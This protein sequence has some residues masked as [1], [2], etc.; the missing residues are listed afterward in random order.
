MNRPAG[1]RTPLNKF[2]WGIIPLRTIFCRVSYLA[3]QISSG[4]QTAVNKFL[5]GL[6]NTF[7]RVSYLKEQISEEYRGFIYWRKKNLPLGR[8]Y[9]SMSFGGKN[10]K[11]QREIGGKC[12]RKRKKVERN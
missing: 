8:G 10:M 9:Q 11:S 4:Y 2:L 7:L 5:Q 6:I 12:K 3:E 1:Y